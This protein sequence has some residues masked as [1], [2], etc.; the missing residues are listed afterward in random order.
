MIYTPPMLN[1]ASNFGTEEMAQVDSLAH[2]NLS[3]PSPPDAFP[4]F[5]RLPTGKVSPSDCV[6]NPP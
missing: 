6:S 3:D 5:M 4:S 1:C 2:S